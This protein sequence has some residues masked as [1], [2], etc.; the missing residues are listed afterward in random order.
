MI[1]ALADIQRKLK[2]RA[3]QNEEDVRFCLVGRVLK[4]LGW[5]IWNPL[6]VKCECIA[7]PTE[8]RTKA[9]IALCLR[10]E[11]PAVFM[12]VKAVGKIDER[13]LRRIEEQLR[14]YNRNLTALFTVLTDGA[15]WRFYY[16]QTGGDFHQKL[17]KFINLLGEVA[18]LEDAARDFRAFLGKSEIQEGTAETQAE[19]L[20]KMTRKEQAMARALPEAQRMCQKHPYPSLIQA[21]M[22]ATSKETDVTE[23]EA[24]DFLGKRPPL[25]TGE[26]QTKGQEPKPPK[27]GPGQPGGQTGTPI[28][29]D[30]PPD[31]RHTS[32]SEA[33]IGER[34]A[35]FWNQL[36]CEAIRIGLDQGHGA[37]ELAEWGRC[38]VVE[39][40]KTVTGYH[41]IGGTGVSYQYK[42]DA[43]GAWQVALSL[44]KRLNVPLSVR[45][46]WSDQEEAAYPGQE[47]E[48]A[49]PPA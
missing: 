20:L 40:H 35:T 37:A 26:N 9:D 32:V 2:D 21:L 28:D 10:P 29:P 1:D 49:W 48:M 5:D 25:P 4:E 7:V 17:F 18:A 6:E 12:E 36:A 13:N 42:A 30:R 16:S 38:N 24:K 44:A 47:G 14:D 27:H 41:P 3:Y 19:A 11:E 23:D 46:S 39:G 34:R 43:N 8:D 45:F 31:L 15:T 33:R 22:M